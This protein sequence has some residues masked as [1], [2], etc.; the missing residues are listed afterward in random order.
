MKDL[1]G[2]GVNDVSFTLDQGEILGISGLM[3]AGRTELMKIIYGARKRESGS[4]ILNGKTINPSSPQDGLANGI[5]L[6]LRRP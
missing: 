6:Y 1:S 4:V 3:G 5:G 2:P